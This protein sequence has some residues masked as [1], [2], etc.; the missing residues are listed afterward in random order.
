MTSHAGAKEGGSFASTPGKNGGFQGMWSLSH[1]HKHTVGCI[2]LDQS[3]C[4]PLKLGNEG[5][6]RRHEAHAASHVVR[7]KSFFSDSGLSSVSV[8]RTM[9]SQL[10]AYKISDSSELLTLTF[11]LL[12]ISN[13]KC[14]RVYFLSFLPTSRSVCCLQS[15]S[16]YSALTEGMW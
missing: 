4:C 16:C 2:C 12:C 14:I 3:L 13:V 15:V 11:K 5:N 6:Q 1:S 9:A 10:F 8:H 7:I